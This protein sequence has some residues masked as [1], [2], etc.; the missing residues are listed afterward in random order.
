LFLQRG[1]RITDFFYT[2]LLH[3]LVGSATVVAYRL[4]SA[5]FDTEGI[6]TL[7]GASFLNGLASISITLIM[8]YAVASILGKSTAL[9]LMDLSRPDHPLLQFI[10][11]NSPGSYQHSLQVANLAEQAAREIDADPLL[12]RVGALYHDAGKALNPSFFIE[13]QVSGNINTHDDIDPVDSATTIIKHVEDGLKLAK[14]YHIPPQIQAFI[15]EHHGKSVTKY[16]LSKAKKDHE[17]DEV[18][19]ESKF[20]YPGPNPRTRET[21]ILMM[22]DKVEAR[23]RAELPKDDEDLERIV[24][25]SI[26]SLL[27][28]GY[29]DNTSLT[30]KNIQTIK[31]SFFNT[32]KNTY[33][34]RIQYPK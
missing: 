26:D 2:G 9:Q 21:A 10:M 19:D 34:P 29:L 25:S 7:I 20:E 15:S 11:T 4:I 16:Q 8:Q 12:A 3:G 1:R 31:E 24:Q 27:R 30:L 6:L 13:N 23:A 14:D 22:A 33:H 5:Y 32:L 28:E 18:F 17:N